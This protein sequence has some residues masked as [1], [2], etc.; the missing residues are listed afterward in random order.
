MSSMGCSLIWLSGEKSEGS[1]RKQNLF[2]CFAPWPD[3]KNPQ[4]R[5]DLWGTFSTGKG[6]TKSEVVTLSDTT[7]I[8][9]TKT[10]KAAKPFLSA[11]GLSFK[12]IWGALEKLSNFSFLDQWFKKAKKWGILIKKIFLDVLS[13]KFCFSGFSKKISSLAL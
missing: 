1:F 6:A 8:D 4:Q 12:L 2:Y 3:L 9:L 10:L 11:T 13:A 7:G 5:I